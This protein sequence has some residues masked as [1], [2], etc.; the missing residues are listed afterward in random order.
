MSQLG[1]RWRIDGVP[2]AFITRG[3]GSGHYRVT[4]ERGEAALEQI[5]AIHWAAPTVERVTESLSEPG[6]PEGYGFELTELC[7]QHTS[8]TF[9]AEVQ[10]A[11]QYWGDVSDYQAQL[12]TLNETLTQ[13]QK[14]LDTQTRQLETLEADLTAAYQEGVEAHG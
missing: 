10:T 7:Y 2:A 3:P 6:L 4:F 8:Q 12:K 11:R 5:E 14:A 9:V 1:I 13:R